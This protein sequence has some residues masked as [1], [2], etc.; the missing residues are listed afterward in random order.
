MTRDGDAASFIRALSPFDAT[1][2]VAGS[3][4][5]SGI[6]IVT[7]DIARQVPSPFWLLMVWVATG[8]LTVAAA[9]SYGELAAMFPGA[10]GQYVYL[11]EAFGPMPGFLYGWTLFLV[12]QTGTIAAV[13]VAF[14]RFL[15]VLVPWVSAD[16]RLIPLSLHGRAGGVDLSLTTERVVAIAVIA[17]LT[18]VN[19]RG[20][21]TAKWVQNLFTATKIAALAL[22]VLVPL[23]GFS[24]AALSAN[25]SAGRF[26]GGLPA[27]GGVV[28]AFGAA[29]VG[30][31]F[32]SDAWNNITFAGEEVKN[33]HRTL[34]FSMAMGTA[35]VTVL[36][37][38][39]NLAYLML[40]PLA[41]SSGGADVVA[42]GIQ[43]AAQDRVGTAAVQVLFGAHG[44]VIMAVL[45][46]ISTFGCENGLILA[47]PRLYYAMARDGLFFRAAARLNP[48]AVPA[49]GL[50]LQGVWASLLTLSGTYGN[51][52]DYIIFAALLFYVGTIAAI[53]ALRR[54]RPGLPRPYRAPGYPLVP[55]LYMLCAL[56]IMV[57]L[58][59]AKP[60]YTSSGLLIVLTGLPVYYFWHH[61]PAA[62][63]ARG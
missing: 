38:L 29:M 16:H 57:V 21:R 51:L 23:A 42:R 59:V 24:A 50:I 2:V 60:A 13:A 41:G 14:A 27:G 17:L 46:M 28:L 58:L 20:I 40:L 15:G 39:A 22:L 33:P 62:G 8:V 53:F 3:M 32:A 18:F 54:A 1:M 45:V 6:F 61:R 44:A 5:G 34:P 52:L 26:F 7:A 49:R 37:V 10:G 25:F 9:L 43:G 55:G 19:T 56:A 11:R 36:Y 63:A 31:L 35:L 47:G 48:H 30:S 12:I 4:I